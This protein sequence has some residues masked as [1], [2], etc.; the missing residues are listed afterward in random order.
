M[1]HRLGLFLRSSIG[2]KF[3]MSLTGAGLMAFVLVHLLGNLTLFADSTGQAFD[4]YSHVLESNPL[5]PLAEIGLVV[6]FVVHL[7][8]GIRLA[9]DNR[10]ARP[11]RYKDLEAHGE[12][13]YASLTMPVTGLLVLVFLVVH[14]LDFRLAERA[15]EGLAA[16]VVQRLRA[17]LSALVYVVGV[18]AL[19]IH[20]WHAFQSAF[21]SL[22][23]FQPRYRLLVRN[24]GR[25][26]AVA[27]ALGFVAF[28][29]AIALAPEGLARGPEP[30]AEL[31]ASS[32]DA[33]PTDPEPAAPASAARGDLR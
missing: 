10:D 7:A 23:L 8:L 14:L 21:Q 32:E 30:G 9:L 22:G 1:L 2:R 20:L 11:K 6:L 24:A 4:R 18:V 12:R 25:V 15:P 33:S 5:L 19:G 3:L 27:I 26:F 17:P 28:P 31:P 16:M 29:L 13:S